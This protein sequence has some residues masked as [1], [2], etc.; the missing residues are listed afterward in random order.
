MSEQG[1]SQFTGLEVA[2]IGMA[3]RFPGARNIKRFWENLKNGVESITILTD[4]ELEA[5]GVERELYTSPNYVK[6][7]GLLDQ[8][9]YFDANFFGYNPKDAQMLDPQIRI[10]TECVW[11]VLEDAGYDP[12][13][14]QGLIGLYA[15]AGINYYWEALALTVQYRGRLG[16]INPAPTDG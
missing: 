13:S 14:Y 10:F 15:G 11:E 7:K 3:G 4:A 8:V 2:V 6:A 9:E 16:T 1:K 5:A 12:Y